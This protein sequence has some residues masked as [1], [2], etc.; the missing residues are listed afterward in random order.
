MQAKEEQYFRYIEAVLFWQ[1]EIQTGVFQ[2]KFKLSRPSARRYLTD[3]IERHD[4]A[5]KYDESEKAYVLATPF[6]PR[7]ISQDFSEYAHLIGELYVHQLSA[8]PISAL[9]LPH[10]KLNPI[11]LRP[12]LNAC[13]RQSVLDICYQSIK[14]GGETDRIIR[15]HTLI[16]SGLRYHL[17]A[18]CEKA[19]GFRDFSLSRI[20]S[21]EPEFKSKA[22]QYKKDDIA[23]QQEVTLTI[24][25]DPR[26]SEYA[27]HVIAHDFDMQSHKKHL[28]TNAALVNYLMSILRLDVQHPNPEAQQIVMEPD[29]YRTLRK[30]KL[31]WN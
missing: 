17:R 5:A 30:Q 27:Q 20:V 12:I 16:N 18:Y 23:W 8:S 4:I 13:R 15:P 26:L 11:I 31:L 19:Q 25:P 6:T 9:A 14:E 7:Y 3:Y 10:R 2:D 29:C 24:M 22:K 1:A 21:A 28:K